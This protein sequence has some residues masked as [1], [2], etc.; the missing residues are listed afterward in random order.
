[1]PQRQYKHKTS[2][3][4]KKNPDNGMLSPSTVGQLRCLFEHKHWK[5]VCDNEVS[6]YMRF[7]RTLAKLKQEEQEFI[8]ELTS[9]FEHIPSGMYVSELVKPLE[10]LRKKK[11]KDILYF[12]G[13]LEEEDILEYELKSCAQVLYQIKGTTMQQNINLKPYLVRNSIAHLTNEHIDTI[14]KNRATLVLVDDYIGTGDTA[15]SALSGVSHYHPELK[16]WDRVCFLAIAAQ[17]EGKMRLEN[18]G[19]EVYVARTMNRGISDN[20]HGKELEKSRALMKQIEYGLRRQ[21]QRK[22][23]FG[24]KHSE[25]LVCME[26]CPNNTFPIYWLPKNDAPYERTGEMRK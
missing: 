14:N 26:R 21:I 12:I 22:F 20:Y 3:N 16:K 19:Y 25:A 23:R 11:P 4:R 2:L 18:A 9:R 10:K 8:L 24:Y 17:E 6:C 5:I 13:C 15:C 1:M 7:I